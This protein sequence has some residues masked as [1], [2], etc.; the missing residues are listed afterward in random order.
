MPAL[1]LRFGPFELRLDEHRLL[2]EGVEVTVQPAAFELLAHFVHR[3]G[4][5]LTREDLLRQAWSVHV[6]DQ[7][8]SQMVRRV[9]VA[10]GEDGTGTAWLET[11][12]GRG[13]RFRGPVVEV[14]AETPPPPGRLPSIEDPPG[15]VG[16][17]EELVALRQ[18]LDAHR[19][20]TVLGPGGIG[21]TRLA[22][23]VAA[24]WGGEGYSAWWCELQAVRDA[25][26]VVDALWAGRG[27]GGGAGADPIGE[28][29]AI[30]GEDLLVLDNVEQVVDPVMPVVSRLLAEAPGV[31]FLLTSRVRLGLPAERCLELGPLP[32]EQAVALL[33]DRADAVRLGLGRIEPAVAQAI[34][35]RLGA[36]PL[37]LVL[38]AP[39]LLLMSPTDLRDR[40]AD[41]G[42][43][44]R[45]QGGEVDRSASL[46]ASIR[47]S[48]ELLDLKARSAAARSA[49]FRGPFGVDA[50]AAVLDLPDLVGALT[51]LRDRSWLH[52][53]AGLGPRRLAMLEPVR[54]WL[55][56]RLAAEGELE[57]LR[58]RHARHFAGIWAE[59]ERYEHHVGELEDLRAA[60]Q[61]AP[62]ALTRARVVPVFVHAALERVGPA[63]LQAPLDQAV[64]DA[65]AAAEP[66][67]LAMLLCQRG[68]YQGLELGQHEVAAADLLRARQLAREAGALRIEARALSHLGVVTQY[69]GQRAEGVAIQTR[70]V[71]LC[72]QAA[73]PWGLARSLAGLGH[74]LWKVGEIDRAVGV[75]EEA[76]TVAEE[77][78]V[79]RWHV[80]AL[81]QLADIAY[82]R[83][84]L[85][86]HDLRDRAARSLVAG[87][88]DRKARRWAD[89]LASRN[90]M[91]H[92]RFDQAEAFALAA[93]QVSAGSARRGTLMRLV[94][95]RLARGDLSGALPPLAEAEVLARKTGQAD[96]IG[97]VLEVR[98]ALDAALGD[99]SQ[100]RERGEELRVIA[101]G[102]D[103]A[104]RLQ[105]TCARYIFALLDGEDPGEPPVADGE[106]GRASL[107]RALAL[108]RAARARAALAPDPDAERD[109][110]PRAGEPPFLGLL[111]RAVERA[112]PVG[113]GLP[114]G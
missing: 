37:A 35:E 74:A 30:L 20:V 42:L 11:V 66:A 111:W 47:W 86:A 97:W 59:E 113:P 17:T 40:L 4:V 114:A 107:R 79:L 67:L 73:W 51:V 82:A 76:V 31:R 72:R 19:M 33:R 80:F 46:E 2:R 69:A 44:L 64:D 68:W 87:T 96:H 39:G 83:G 32:A 6:S 70:A 75:L 45:A 43:S 5:L 63:G 10:L 90:A 106:V 61:H 41:R 53:A 29:A 15:F 1:R 101:L 24:T 50:A 21:K 77:A 88:E 103:P 78:L 95:A 65:T 71:A 36:I 60:V 55:E 81:G 112:W 12:R 54:A 110:R 49:V 9:R 18:A 13:Y 27:L 34:V 84:E 105:A 26:G 98:A 89:E 3:P 25:E 52:E 28:L 108:A 94:N 91:A 48:W 99:L 62:D 58:T 104:D 93:L 56:A 7:S 14:E 23:R 92:G 8:L 109:A 85:S 22:R 38:A 16:R 102:A 57:V 100:A